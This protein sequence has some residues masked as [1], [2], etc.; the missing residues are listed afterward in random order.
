MLLLGTAYCVFYSNAFQNWLTGKLGDYLSAQFK[1]KISI[2]H[3]NY[4][5]LQTF[6]LEDVLFGDHKNDTLFYAGSLSFNLAG[7]NLDSTEFK[8]SDVKVDRGYCQIRFYKDGSFN[9]H[10]LDNITDPNDTLPSTGPPFQ[11]AFDNV[12]CEH[13]R[14]KFIDETDTSAWENFAPNNEFFYDISVKARD[15]R[16]INDSLHFVVDHLAAK[17]ISGFEAR[18]IQTV[19]TIAPSCMLFEDLQIKTPRTFVEGNYFMRYRDWESFSDFY[20]NVKLEARVRSSFVDLKDIAFF[21]SPFKEYNYRLK[22]SGSGSG[23]VSN[24]KLRNLDVRFGRSGS[25]RGKGDL[26]GLPDIENT[27]IDAEATQVVATKS[28]IEYLAQMPVADEMKNL[29]TILFRGKYTGFYKDFVA[30]GK[31][32]TAIG[33]AESDL[34]MKIADEAEDY[35]YSGTLVLNDFDLG[36]FTQNSMLGRLSA[37]TRVKGKGLSYDKMKAAV[38]AEVPYF[39]LNKYAY[40]DIKVDGGLDRKVIAAKMFVNDPNLDLDFDGT[41]N[42]ASDIPKYAFKAR[43]GHANLQPLGLDTS[44]ISVSALADINFSWKDIDHNDGE[45]DLTGIE[46]TSHDDLYTIDKLYI[47]SS[48]LAGQR[49]ININSDN[50]AADIYGRFAFSQIPDAFMKN[51]AG[52]APGYFDQQKYEAA[53]NQYFAFDINIKTLYPFNELFFKNIEIRNAVSKGEFNQET[54]N[55]TVNGY[56]ESFDYNKMQFEGITFKQDQSGV[57]EAQIMA[58]LKQLVISDT[59]ITRDAALRVEL[60]KNLAQTHFIVRDSQSL[61]TANIRNDIY[62]IADSIKAVFS[63]SRVS[64][65]K[66]DFRIKGKSEVVYHP[67]GILFNDFLITR[68][69]TENIQLNGVYGFHTP[70][71]LLAEVNNFHLDVVNE[72]FPYLTIAINGVLDGSLQLKSVGEEWALSSDASL[73]SLSLDKDTVGD[74]KIVTNYLEQQ[75]RLMAYLRSTS[76]KLRNLECSG[77]YDFSHPSDALNFNINFDESD[78]TSFQA[79]VKGYITLYAGSARARGQLAGSLKYPELNCDLE[80]MGVT[81]VV[82]YLKTMYSFSTTVN[83]NEQQIRVAPTEVRDINDRKATLTGYITHKNFSEPKLNLKLNEMRNFQVLNTKAKDNNLFYGTAYVNGG[84]SLTGP[85]NDLIMDANLTAERNSLINI[86]LSEGYDA[87]AD[88]LLH[89]VNRDT[90]AR[91]GEGRRS[92]SISGF[93]IN[94]M[95]HVTKDAEIQIVFDEQQGDKIRGRG[96]GDLKLELTRSGQFNMYGEVEIEEGDYRFTAMNLFT[97]KFTLKRGGTITWTGDP[98]Q[99][100]MNITGVYSLRTSVGDIV[101]SI[102]REAVAQQRIPV[103]CLLYLRGNLL[104]PDIKFDMNMYDL[105]GS[106][107]NSAVSEIQNLLR[108]WR[109]ENDLMTQQVVSLMLFGRFTPTNIQN[110]TGPTSLSAGVDN[111]LSG[112]VSAQATGFIQQLIPGLDVNVDYHTGNE[113][114]RGRTILSASKRIFD[115]RLELQANV[116]PINTYQ[117]FLTQYNLTRDG[118]LKAKAFSRAQSDPIFN[119]NINTQGIG[120]YYRKEF[121]KFHELFTRRKN[122]NNLNN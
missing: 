13:T 98:F 58:G 31:F 14:F 85:F 90:L 30:Y 112:F 22:I 104:K 29:G 107:S 28:D 71:A 92:G 8:L 74:F 91:T 44:G 34:N 108:L 43:L 115:N 89:F 63:P 120:L 37:N 11:L 65:M 16:I 101:S 64:Y 52:L 20:N 59:V 97:K 32:T 72:L 118:N 2:G 24:M 48:N 41:I 4:K 106:L 62:F 94:C 6:E 114:V 82:D 117:N 57:Q 66:S 33:T 25:F 80:L 81:L 121:D 17:E 36:K 15:F 105:N 79:F 96:T 88:G 42:L 69:K 84:L 21:A 38:I 10:V 75:R 9:I 86:P 67:S 116:D 47:N 68:N 53:S 49:H 78:I 93:T 56:V 23:T 73:T 35:E 46:V 7:M 18:H 83:I 122:V 61:F 50:I 19:V 87:G 12:T 27:F 111:T 95:L 51:L 76:G 113:S 110:S 39:E 26:N 45:I 103:E 100:Q 70:H 40:R 1:T 109:S 54:H 119:R 5:P 55:V 99:G 60:D 3:I 77:F 102:D